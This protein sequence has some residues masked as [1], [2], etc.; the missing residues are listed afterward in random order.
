MSLSFLAVSHDLNNLYVARNRGRISSKK[1]GENGTWEMGNS[2]FFFF[3]FFPK[4]YHHD[5]NKINSRSL[6]LLCLSSFLCFPKRGLGP[7]TH[8][9]VGRLL[10]AALV[11]LWFLEP[12]RA[13]IEHLFGP[14]KHHYRTA[15]G[16]SFHFFLGFE[17]FSPRQCRPASGRNKMRD[18]LIVYSYFFLIDIVSNC[19]QIIIQWPHNTEALCQKHCKMADCHNLSFHKMNSGTLPRRKWT[20]CCRAKGFRPWL[21]HK[22]ELCHMFPKASSQLFCTPCCCVKAEQS[23]LHPAADNVSNASDLMYFQCIVFSPS[24][25]YHIYNLSSFLLESCKVHDYLPV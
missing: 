25:L 3:F 10:S 11:T 8:R 21:S 7:I 1:P 18:K 6:L 15:C 22:K 17:H 19:S 12:I 9:S 2:S 14:W 13:L 5:F 4:P 23:T 16:C 24:F 20:E